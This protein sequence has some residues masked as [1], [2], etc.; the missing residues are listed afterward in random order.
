VQAH[1]VSGNVLYPGF[2]QFPPPVK[3]LHLILAQWGGEVKG[4]SQKS[5]MKS[6][7]HR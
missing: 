3:T 7:K 5:N 2:S 4:L 1:A 6:Q